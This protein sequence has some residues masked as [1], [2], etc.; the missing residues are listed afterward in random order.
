[1]KDISTFIELFNASIIC[2]QEIDIFSA[3]KE[4]KNI[5]QVYVNYDLEGNNNIGIVT[6]IRKDIKVIDQI[7]STDGRILGIKCNQFQ[8]WNVYPVS[9]T[10][11]KNKRELFFREELN[12]LMMN[13]KDHSKIFQSGDHNCIHRKEDSLNNAA[14]HLQP[15][16]I[17]HM[18]IHGLKDDFIEVHGPDKIEY[19]RITDKSKTRIDYIL[20]NTN[21]CTFFE[22]I[23]TGLRL[24]HKAVHAKY[25]IDF[26]VIFEKIPKNHF[27]PMWVIPKFLEEDKIFIQEANIIF[28]DIFSAYIQSG[29]TNVS[30]YWQQSKLFIKKIAKRR[31][32]TLKFE[33]Q[34]RMEV[35]KVYYAGLLSSLNDGIDC[36]QEI[37]NIKSEICQIQKNR[38]RKLIDKMRK[39]EIE[40]HVYDIHKLQRERK[41]EN[42]KKIKDIKIDDVIFSGTEQV[43]SGIKNK[44]MEELKPFGDLSKDDPPTLNEISFLEMIPHTEWTKEEVDNLIGPTT[45]EEIFNILKYEVDL[46]SSPGEDGITYRFIKK[47][48]NFKSYRTLFVAFLNYTRYEGHLGDVSNIGTMIVKNKK[49]QSMEYEK[50]RKLTKVNKDINLGHGK[51]WTN[52]M[53]EIV[54]PKILPKTQFNC[55]KDINI[56]S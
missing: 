26:E 19:S 33:E 5:Y 36:L 38:S 7:I 27:H 55:Q 43:V 10:T 50:K 40:D 41:Y 46:D 23:D 15:G 29:E 54:L 53:K 51:V 31:E 17:A 24:D 13:W 56:T 44:M 47:F 48:W 16:L 9:G 12:N 35:L 25:D 49:N 22:Y 28:D 34:N 11:Y 6:L 42:N 37:K 14:Q 18:K 4:F 2:I 52:R 20:S 21:Q 30:F 39:C 8:V 1:M 45:E 32:K 3:L